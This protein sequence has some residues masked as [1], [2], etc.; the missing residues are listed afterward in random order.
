MKFNVNV[1]LILNSVNS[2]VGTEMVEKVTSQSN[3][4]GIAISTLITP[5]N[6]PPPPPAA[7]VAFAFVGGISFTATD[8]HEADDVAAEAA[9]ARTE[10]ETSCKKLDAEFAMVSR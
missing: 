1:K 6:K 5:P 3:T 7:V 4:L 10:V 9:A 2:A 8:D